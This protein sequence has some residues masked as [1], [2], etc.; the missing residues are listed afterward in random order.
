[1]ESDEKTLLE[2]SHDNQN[3]SMTTEDSNKS[4][5]KS[6][7]HQDEKPEANVHA[8]DA[9]KT[10]LDT[11]KNSKAADTEDTNEREVTE[12]TVMLADDS[13][14]SS[15]EEDVVDAEVFVDNVDNEDSRVDDM[16]RR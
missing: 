5:D 9:D 11:N 16:T 7:S 10:E 8:L 15:D 6:E 3:I 4:D 2:L 13:N 14:T 12:K 1:M